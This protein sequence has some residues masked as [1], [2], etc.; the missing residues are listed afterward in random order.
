VGQ[1]PAVAAWAGHAFACSAHREKA[2]CSNGH[3]I[4]VPDLNRRVLDG[5]KARLLVPGALAEFVAEY[6][7][8]RTRLAGEATSQRAELC[9]HIGSLGKEIAN[10]VDA[11]AEGWAPFRRVAS[12]RASRSS[13]NTRGAA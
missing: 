12:S 1:P 3:I 5:L 6:H 2:T 7:R 9:R 11:I 10:I 4:H 8:E 13:A